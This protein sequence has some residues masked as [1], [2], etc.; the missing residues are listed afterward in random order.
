MVND[1]TMD[2]TERDEWLER[3][4]RDGTGRGFAMRR[5]IRTCDGLDAK[6][7]K[8]TKMWTDDMQHAGKELGRVKSANKHLHE[9]NT[10]LKQL[11]AA[12]LGDEAATY[13]NAAN[14]ETMLDEKV[15]GFT[16]RHA[17]LLKEMF[18]YDPSLFGTEASDGQA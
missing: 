12:V 10:K 2:K 18:D 13:T 6:V 1:E 11:L 17:A 14:I 3:L 9:S 5:L 8:A 16:E 7:A 15:D 4:R